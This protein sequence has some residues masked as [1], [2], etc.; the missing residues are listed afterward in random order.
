ME[1]IPIAPRG[2]CKGVYQAIRLAKKTAQENPGVK[3]TILGQLVH[4]RYVRD[5]LFAM[6][7]HTAD[8]PKVSRLE[9]LDTIDEGIVI[10]TAHGVSAK[11]REEA[12]RR[13]LLIAD[14]TC[15]DVLNT[16]SLIESAHAIN[17][18]IF[19]IGKAGHPESQAVIESF[20]NIFLIES[21]QDIPTLNEDKEIFVTNQ[22]TMSKND[23][24]HI[25]NEILKQYPNAQIANEI[26]SA[27][28][29]RQQAIEKIKQADA[30]IVVGDPQSNNTLMLAKI[31]EQHGIKTVCRI[32]SVEELDTS[33]LKEDM[34]VAVTAGASTPAKL[35][36]Q[37]ID[38]LKAYDFQD[39]AELPKVDVSVILDE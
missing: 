11:I 12:A 2:F 4:N 23:I 17:Q 33:I 30:L 9:L 37:V 20:T 6:G 10:F 3:V 22:T 16:Q 24:E 13:N 28:R 8:D 29:L 15:Q 31:A 34:R 36:Q 19:Y 7:I 38:Y 21:A 14:A 32:E 5:A 26:C 25:I 27:T 35:T 18:T 39:P 1:V